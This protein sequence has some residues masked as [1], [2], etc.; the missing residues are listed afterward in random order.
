MNVMRKSFF[1]LL[2]LVVGPGNLNS[3][4]LPS[5]Q[6]ELSSAEC[7]VYS[8]VL[9]QSYTPSG[10]TLFVIDDH[11]YSSV[12]LDDDIAG[13]FRYVKKHIPLLSQ[14]AINDYKT[15]NRQSQ[16]LARLFKLKIDYVL[17]SRSKFEAL[18]DPGGVMEMSRIGWENFYR[19]YRETSG[20]LSL[21]RVGF[22][23]QRNQA[24]VYVT[25]TR[26]NPSGREWGAESYVLLIKKNG[27]WRVQGH[28]AV[29]VS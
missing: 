11:T 14:V 3:F 13:T 1:A 23:H 21:S 10:A 16:P 24:L 25:D 7:A 12:G 4:A 27:R 6:S 22:D 8:A 9:E 20:F 29:L 17:L 26:G 19:E 2:L 5:E 15:R 18:T 28:V